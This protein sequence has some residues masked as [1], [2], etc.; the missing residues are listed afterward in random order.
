MRIPTASVVV[1]AAV[2]IAMTLHALAKEPVE[3]EVVVE[4]PVVE[5]AEKEE[6]ESEPIRVPDLSKSDI[7]L[8]ALVTMAEAE[9]ETELGQRLVI[10]VILNRM[11]HSAFPS[12]VEDVVYQTNQFTSVWNGRIDKCVA[13][14][15]II[16]LVEDEL[17][18]RTNYEVVFFRTGHYSI[19]GNPLFQE[20]NHYFSSY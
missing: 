5:T 9:G 3:E 6:V 17:E 15:S 1:L 16:S 19:Y 13:L 20:G 14:P 10:D 11:E 8:I 4:T 18:G 12:T 7:S 2:L